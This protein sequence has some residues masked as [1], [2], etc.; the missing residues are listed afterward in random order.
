MA[1]SAVPGSP[2]QYYQLI[3]VQWPQAPNRFPVGNPTPGLLANVTMETYVTESSCI[4]CHFTARTASSKLSSDYSFL[5]AEA[6]SAGA[7]GSAR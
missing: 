2:F 5:L 6:K 1:L 7:S 4:N 3:D